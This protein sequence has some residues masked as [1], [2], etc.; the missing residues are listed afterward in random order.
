[1]TQRTTSAAAAVTTSARLGLALVRSCSPR[2]SAVL[3]FTVA[4]SP[5]S[6]Q[7]PDFQRESVCYFPP[8]NSSHGYLPNAIKNA[9]TLDLRVRGELRKKKFLKFDRSV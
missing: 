1:V 4:A 8:N 5:D 9:S 7:T 2:Q 3:N 6:S